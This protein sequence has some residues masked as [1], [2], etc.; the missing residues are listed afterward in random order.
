MNLPFRID[1][2]ARKPLLAAGG[3]EQV[4]MDAG[5]GAI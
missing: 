4:L 3:R 5:A 2:S 1:F